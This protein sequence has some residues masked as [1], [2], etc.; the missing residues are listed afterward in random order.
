MRSLRQVIRDWLTNDTDQKAPSI[1]AVSAG[2]RYQQL[3]TSCSMHFSIFDAIGGKV[4][5]FKRRDR[6]GDLETQA[7]YIIPSTENFSER[8]EKIIML[9]AMK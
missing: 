7:V 6:H 4:V 2:G 8:I 3:D 1:N 9:E 5:E